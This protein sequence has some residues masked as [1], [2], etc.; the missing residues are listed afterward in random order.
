MGRKAR[1]KLERR[2]EGGSARPSRRRSKW[3][4]GMVLALVVVGGGLGAWLWNGARAAPEPAPK[5]NLLS[6]TGRVITIDDFLGKQELVLIFYM[7][8]G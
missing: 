6:S 8:A 4:V 7:G 5:F 3:V 1:M 2:N